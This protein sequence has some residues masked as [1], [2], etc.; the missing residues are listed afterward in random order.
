MTTGSPLNT[1]VNAAGSEPRGGG[2]AAGDGS[3][4]VFLHDLPTR[5]A[6][7][8]PAPTERRSRCRRLGRSQYIANVLHR[9]HR[10]AGERRF[11]GV[12][13]GC[14][15]RRREH[16]SRGT[17]IVASSSAERGRSLSAATVRSSRG[18]RRSASICWR[19]RGASALDY[20]EQDGVTMDRRSHSARPLI[21]VDGERHSRLPP[22]RLAVGRR[23]SLMVPAGNALG[24]E[25]GVYTRVA[26]ATGQT[27][28]DYRPF[29]RSADGFNPAPFNYS[30]TPNDRT[31]LWLLGSHPLSESANLFVEALAHKRKSRAAGTH[32]AFSAV[33]LRC[34]P[35]AQRHSGRTTTTTH[36]EST[37]RLD[38]ARRVVEA[39]NRVISEERR[40]MAC[41]LGF[42]GYRRSLAMAAGGRKRQVRGDECREGL[43]LASAVEPGCRAIRPGRF[44]PHR[45][46]LTRS[47]H[48]PRACG[49]HH[50][51]LCA[52]QSF[53]RGRQHHAGPGGLCES[54]PCQYRYE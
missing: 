5:R 3:F 51:G 54:A 10:S 37:S 20:V 27:A 48:R 36:S 12:R 19:E 16:R 41:A 18:R 9:S 34:L 49:A 17:A 43:F 29:V 8:W 2:G 23:S 28:A 32:R 46:W 7:Q 47:R 40:S 31:S 38:V 15:G 4:R 11:S 53:R 21:I 44:R 33:G 13:H 24:L 14:R 45:L 26:G 39:G 42:E 30:Q 35:T 1:N 6:A 50:C 52:A 25:P 22:A